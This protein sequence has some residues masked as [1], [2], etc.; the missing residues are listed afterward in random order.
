MDTG[1]TL[2]TIE[3][4]MR[5]NHQQQQSQQAPH[6]PISILFP[7]APGHNTFSEAPG[8]T[9]NATTFPP[10]ASMPHQAFPQHRP[11]APIPG[12]TL[13]PFTP[14]AGP[15]PGRGAE[16]PPWVDGPYPPH[17]GLPPPH[18]PMQQ[19]QIP[20]HVPRGPW[21]RTGG[22]SSELQDNRSP[23]KRRRPDDDHANRDR[24]HD[25]RRS[26][27][28]SRHNHHRRGEPLT[29]ERTMVAGIQLG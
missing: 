20:V 13:L 21:E 6:A 18:P 11:N 9:Q 16:L 10:A 8:P 15:Q 1:E 14:V 26:S 19:P 2:V 25:D 12:S 3:E 24:M 28:D 7:A 5:Y 29:K 4:A 22:P 27:D 23:H 17:A